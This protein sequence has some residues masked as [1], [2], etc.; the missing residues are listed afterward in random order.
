MSTNSK[1]MDK[2][3]RV[4]T[5]RSTSRMSLVRRRV[6]D[7]CTRWRGTLSH[8]LCSE[9]QHTA[10]ACIAALQ[11][12]TPWLRCLVP[13]RHMPPSTSIVTVGFLTYSTTYPRS[14]E[15][16]RKR[17]LTFSITYPRSREN[18]GK[19]YLWFTELVCTALHLH[20]FYSFLPLDF[21]PYDTT[22]D[23]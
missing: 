6:V 21:L 8:H 20:V 18:L 16:L 17:Y 23:P 13:Q 3:L 1:A 4:F 11:R 22:T 2:A 19:R 10:R 14:R 7:G 5:L 9:V 15:K 12:C